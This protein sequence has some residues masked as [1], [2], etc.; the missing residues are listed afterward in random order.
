M[1]TGRRSPKSLEN[2]ALGTVQRYE[3]GERDDWRCAFEVALLGV[4]DGETHVC[5]ERIVERDGSTVWV[6]CGAPMQDTAHVVRRWVA[7]MHRTDD[8]VPLKFHV[9]VA[10]AG[11]RSCHTR[12][13]SRLDPRVRV[14]ALAAAKA[15]RLIDHTLLA[16]EARNEA[17]VWPWPKPESAP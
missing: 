8:D 17:V 4:M 1:I 14:P 3:V 2:A 15:K 6:R 7:G 13:D 11:C 16:A 9:L 10:I 5:S 12:F